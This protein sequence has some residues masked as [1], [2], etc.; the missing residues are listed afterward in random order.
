MPRGALA[1]VMVVAAA[2]LST[3]RARADDAVTWLPGNSREID[4]NASASRDA[5]VLGLTF[6][7]R[8]E[9]KA[10]A[11]FALAKIAWGGVALRPGFAGFF[12]LEHAEAG[13]SGPLPLPGEGKGVMLWRG[14]FEFS[15]L[16]SAERLA[17]DWLGPRGAL[18][19]GLTVG[20]ESD[21]VTGAS[22]ND[23]PEPGDIVA[24]GGGNFLLYELAMRT[25]LG[26]RVTMWGRVEDRAYWLGP[27]AHAPGVE[28]GVRWHARPHFEPLTSVFGEG[29]LVDHRVNQGSESAAE[30]QRILEARSGG[31]LGWLVGIGLP[32]AFGQVIPYA[33][34]DIGNG[35]GLLIN[36]REMDLSIGVRYA[37]F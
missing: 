27:I 33:A 4:R 28:V 31:F 15:L 9:A 23:A 14:H 35:K 7:P 36:R 12:D 11:D 18:E 26:R 24:G 20:H 19:I 37:P 25:A 1:F 34:L 29:L 8:V 32:G 22:F 6:A 10:A 3:R 13:L 2:A 16:L 30:D 5:P 17:R 21:H